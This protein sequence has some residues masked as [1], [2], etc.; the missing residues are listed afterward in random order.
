M[1]YIITNTILNTTIVVDQEMSEKKRF[2]LTIYEYAIFNNLIFGGEL[3]PLTP[4]P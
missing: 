3:K 2:M 4:P 1:I